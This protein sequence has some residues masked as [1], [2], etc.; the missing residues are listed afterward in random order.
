[1][2]YPKR[3]DVKQTR[4]NVRE[5]LKNFRKLDRMVGRVTVD[6]ESPR[7]INS[8]KA[9][10]SDQS[11]E[12]ASMQMIAIEAER[13]AIINALMVLS[14]TNRMILYYSYFVPESFSN[15]KISLEIGYSERTIQ[16]KKAEALIEFAEAYKSGKLIAYK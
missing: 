15:Y 13:N 11:S 14:L 1:M 7:R 4:C 2:M 5:V 9:T 3:I 6:I 12:R 8:L 10:L 16:R